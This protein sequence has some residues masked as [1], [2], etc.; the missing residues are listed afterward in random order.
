MQK[1]ILSVHYQAARKPR[2]SINL[3][4][5]WLYQLGYRFGD[6]IE[7]TATEDEILIRKIQAKRKLNP[8]K[9]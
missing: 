6:Q 2:P 1:R 5:E 4:G 7:V 8:F 3:K 9:R